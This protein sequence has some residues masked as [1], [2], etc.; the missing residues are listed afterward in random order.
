MTKAEMRRFARI[1][2]QEF[3]RDYPDVYAD[4]AA[5]AAWTRMLVASEEVWPAMPEVPRSVKPKA[6]RMLVDRGLV[7]VTGSTVVLKG[8]VAERT[9]RAE[10]GRTG[11]AKRW[12]SDGNA[13][14]HANAGPMAMQER[15]R[16]RD[17]RE[18]ERDGTPVET[19]EPGVVQ[20]LRTA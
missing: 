9:Q 5:W 19:R 11:A 6:L 1:Y 2:Y 8:W 17:T 7:T 18:A 10:S 12:D 15:G 3:R 16:G 14:A 13:N 20:P 4:Y